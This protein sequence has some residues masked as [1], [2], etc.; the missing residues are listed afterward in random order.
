MEKQMENLKYQ[1]KNRYSEIHGWQNQLDKMENFNRNIGGGNL[2]LGLNLRNLCGAV[3]TAA[4]FGL[5]LA[6]GVCA[7]PG[8]ANAVESK[9]TSKVVPKIKQAAAS[10][11]EVKDP[12]V[13]EVPSSQ[14]NTALFFTLVNSDDREHKLVAVSSDAAKILELHDNIQEGGVMKMRPVK[15]I[16]VGSG[17]HTELKPGSLHVMLLDLVKPVKDGEKIPVTLIFEDGSKKNIQAKVVSLVKGG[18]DSMSG[19]TGHAGEHEHH[20]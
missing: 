6:L 16:S 15:D 9:T 18:N 13:R 20:H 11:I 10:Q 12:Y 2:I 17:H 1:M 7:L 14:Q 4:I 5:V 19:S 8:G 3:L